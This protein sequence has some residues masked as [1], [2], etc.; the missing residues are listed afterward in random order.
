MNFRKDLFYLFLLLGL[1]IIFWGQ[2]LEPGKLLFLRD[3]SIE[4][5]ARKHFW[6]ESHGFALWNPHIFFGSPYATPQ[7][8]AF[9]PFNFLFLIFGAE[10]GLTFYIIF[11]HLFFLLT[12]YLALRRIGYTEAASLLGSVGFGLGGFLISMTLYVVSLSTFAWFGLII[13]FLSGARGKRWMISSLLLGLTMAL[14]ILGGEI[15]IAG[16]SWALAF[17][18]V[19]VS[20]SETQCP[21]AL[22]KLAGV[23]I[24]G[25]FWGIILTLPQIALALELLPIS[26][27]A[28]GMNIIK[29]LFWSLP[30][31][32]LKSFFIPNYFLD[33]TAG[34][35]R[36]LGIFSHHAYYSSFYLAATLLPFGILALTGSS[37]WKC[38]VWLSVLG[39][40]LAMMMGAQLGAYELFYDYFP[41]F[42]LFRIPQ[43]FFLL[44][45]YGFVLLS[46]SGLEVIAGKRRSFPPASLACCFAA[47]VIIIFLL[48]NPLEIQVWGG[49][50][51]GISAY[52]FTRSVLWVSMFSLIML[53]LI[54]GTGTFARSSKGI[55]FALVVFLDLF[56]AHHWLN[57]A[58][59]RDFFKPDHF[60]QEFLTREKGRIEPPRIFSFWPED[61]RIIYSRMIPFEVFEQKYQS[62]PNTLTSFYFGY[63]SLQGLGTFYPKD[64]AKFS[65]LVTELTY[66]RQILARAG[67]EYIYNR[68][69]DFE[70]LTDV[71]PR[72]KVFHQVQEMHDQDQ[73][74]KLWSQ[75]DFAAEELLLIEGDPASSDP[76]PGSGGPE[77]ARIIEYQNEKVVVEAEI[78]K[79]GW[80]L[81]LDS[82][83]PGWEATLDG[84]FTKIYRADGFFRAV[85]IPAGRHR[86]VFNYSPA[87]FK[88][89]V[90]ISGLGFL[91]WLGLIVSTSIRKG[92]RL[93]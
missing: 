92:S 86:I 28:G 78:K 66:Y 20:P 16:L 64:V 90:W 61:Q 87:F 22:A 55:L 7:A 50:S 2:A 65:K 83:Y 62:S 8:G 89:C 80:L 79:A 76:I 74:I 56:L 58:M 43:K 12:F 57:R 32:G 81:L 41:G 11:H 59:P 44:V 72:A 69:Q 4:I 5:L 82:Y 42:N 21:R 9:Y 25:L 45:N 70:K 26:N 37:R 17:L 75:P 84:K 30:V 54:L 19:A 53:G 39:F 60:V 24:L 38:F 1:G 14:Q 91:I 18:T 52:L 13:I 85:R 47:I 6:V 29:A 63:N 88:K 15:E 27:R 33:F 35:S 31:S 48:I 34:S 51:P 46:L 68:Y 3:L 23:M 36:D 10:R 40:G 49:T 73:V 67:V 93:L 77:T 71:L